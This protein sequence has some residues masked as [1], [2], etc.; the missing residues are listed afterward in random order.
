MGSFARAPCILLN[1][2]RCGGDG[3]R[4]PP[5]F[6]R[7]DIDVFARKR[8]R[9]LVVP[10]LT[11]R[12]E[13]GFPVNGVEYLKR[14]RVS[15]ARS[16]CQRH[17]RAGR[18]NDADPAVRQVLSARTNLP[19]VLSQSASLVIPGSIITASRAQRRGGC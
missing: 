5:F 7:S 4:P 9:C 12:Q 8:F 1:Q 11:N 14:R 15:G 19:A 10:N 18:F 2:R 16:R 3:L 6:C 13:A 17:Q